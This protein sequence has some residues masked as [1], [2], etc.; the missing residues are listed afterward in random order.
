MPELLHIGKRFY[1]DLSP[2]D[3]C[4]HYVALPFDKLENYYS[5][6]DTT[7]H[8]NTAEPTPLPTLLSDT[9]ASPNMLELLMKN[10]L[11]TEHHN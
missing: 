7:H 10:Q 3:T 11:F 1:K 8:Y 4:L 6:F 9:A 5:F 2:F